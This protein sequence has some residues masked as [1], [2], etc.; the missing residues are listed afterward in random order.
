MITEKCV[1]LRRKSVYVRS[2]AKCKVQSTKTKYTEQ[3][4]KKLLLSLALVAAGAGF[5]SAQEVTFDF[6]DNTLTYDGTTSGKNVQPLKSV[7]NAGVVFTFNKNTAS[8]DCAWYYILDTDHSNAQIRMYSKSSVKITAP[9]GKKLSKVIFTLAKKDKS[10]PAKNYSNVTADNGTITPIL[11]AAPGTDFTTVTWENTAGAEEVTITVPANKAS[12][13]TGNPQFRFSKA[14]VTISGGGGGPTAPSAPKIN[15]AATFY[16]ANTSITMSAATGC[17]IYY[18]MTAGTTAPADPTTSSLKYDGEIVINGTTSF[19]A[20]AVKNGL[21][22]S[23]TSKTFTKGEAISVSSIADFLEQNNDEVCT[24]TNPVTV[25]GLYNKRYLFVEDATGALQIF[26]GSSKLDR[27]Y[28]MGQTIKGFTVQRGVYNNTPQGNAA[29]F[30]GTFQATA[31]GTAHYINPKS[32]ASTEEAI[33][34]NLNRYVYITGAIT[35]TG[36]N[37]FMNTVQFFDRFSLKLITD[38]MAGQTKDVAGFAVMFKTTPELYYTKVGEPNTLGVNGVEEGTE[39]IY[40]TYGSI[41]APA[42]AQIY[43]MSG[44]KV[45]NGNL[46]AGIYLV[47]NNGKTTKVVVK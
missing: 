16:G 34:A 14:V 33:K 47:R 44:M 41:V 13:T 43:N 27:P 31:D 9:T 17:D 46:P 3:I 24:F 5:A 1:T 40:G 2:M 21:S 15:G 23:V 29:D 22:S 19:K 32:I 7:T 12:W 25:M 20:I 26:D 10:W 39:A 11:T 38:A 4:M 35:K 45:A 6:S 42:D 36:N 8:S 18:T 37:F 30:I 28:E